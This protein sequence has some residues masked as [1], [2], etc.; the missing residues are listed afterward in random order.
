MAYA[1]LALKPSGGNVGIGTIA[2]DSKLHINTSGNT[3][4]DGITLRN[5]TGQTHKWYLPSNTHS[6]FLIG[7]TAGLFSW[8]N[9]NGEL[10]RIN[11]NG[12]V[13]I[14]TTTPDEKLT[15]ADT[16]EVGSHPKLRF[17]RIAALKFDGE[18]EFDAGFKFWVGADSTT[19]P[20]EAFYIRH[21]GYVG[22]G[23]STHLLKF[24]L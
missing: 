16:G 19:L 5:G 20:T 2:P 6:E 23:T 10:L 14:G 4:A 24:L 9:S 13:G 3:A 15:I 18:I 7:S 22:V 8:K 11:S 12:N 17:E 21:D 1:P